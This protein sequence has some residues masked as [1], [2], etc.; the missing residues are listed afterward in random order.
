M[1]A[2]GATPWIGPVVARWGHWGAESLIVCVLG[3]LGFAAQPFG[4]GSLA[5]TLGPIALFCFALAGALAMR[6]HDR[7]L[8]ELC[9]LAM[10]LNAAEAASRYRRQFAVV[11]A[12]ANRGLVIAYL[13]VL[14][15]ADVVL[16][17][18]GTAARICWAVIQSSMVYLVLASSHHRRF[19]PWCPQCQ[20]GDGGGDRK[21]APDLL[22]RSAR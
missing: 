17:Q 13:G 21:D 6:Q 14:V 8:C 12:S 9:V 3:A 20:G 15:A 7:S 18:Q 10:P 16:L 2:D 1:S 5:S 22:P 11:H 4:P 19:Q